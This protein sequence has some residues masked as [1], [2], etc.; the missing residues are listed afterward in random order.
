[1]ILVTHIQ[2]ARW[3][4][5]LAILLGLSSFTL[6]IPSNMALSQDLTFLFSIGGLIAGAV[7]LFIR[8]KGKLAT[9]MAIVGM[10]ISSVLP[11]FVALLFWNSFVAR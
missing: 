1:M 4:A 2:R 6:P 7:T 11:L 8:G 10:I 3:L 5:M 9:V